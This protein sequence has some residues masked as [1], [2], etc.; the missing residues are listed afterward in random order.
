MSDYI[1]GYTG[2]QI[3][4]AVGKVATHETAIEALQ[5]SVEGKAD[6]SDVYS[7]SQVYTKTEI[8]TALAGK[9]ATLTFDNVPTESSN[10]PVKSGG[11]YSQLAEKVNTADVVDNLTTDNASKVLSAKQGKVLKDEVTSQEGTLYTYNNYAYSDNLTATTAQTNRVNYRT[12]N[13][14][15]KAGDKI[16][17]K[18]TATSGSWTRLLLWCNNVSGESS[19]GYRVKDNIANGVEYIV[20]LTEDITIL[21]FYMTKTSQVEFVMYI[22]RLTKLDSETAAE[23]AKIPDMENDISELSESSIGYRQIDSSTFISGK[24]VAPTTNQ[25]RDAGT[26]FSY[27]GSIRTDIIAVNEGDVIETNATFDAS[28]GAATYSANDAIPANFL[29]GISV[30]PSDHK[31]TIASGESY[32]VISCRTTTGYDSKPLWVKLITADGMFNTEISPMQNVLAAFDP[33]TITYQDKCNRESLY[34]QDEKNTFLWKQYDKAYFSWTND[35]A[36]SQDMHLYQ[37]VCAENN[38]P[39]CP[40][41]P[42]EKILTNPTIDGTTL[43]NRCKAIVEAGGEILMHGSTALADDSTEADWLSVFRDG[44]KIIEDAVGCDVNGIIKIGGTTQRPARVTDEYSQKFCLAYYKYS[45]MWGLTDQY[46]CNRTRYEI[47]SGRTEAQALELYKAAIDDAI[48]NH[49]WLR[50][51]CHGTSEVPISLLESIIDYINDTYSNSQY[52]WVTW[53]YMYENFKGYA[54][55]N[56]WVDE[57]ITESN[58]TKTMTATLQPNKVHYSDTAVDVANISFS[59]AYDRTKA[60]EVYIKCRSAN[61]S[62]NFNLGSGFNFA[63][64]AQ[65]STATNRTIH[66][67]IENY[68][69]YADYKD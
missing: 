55:D 2:E 49:K 9:Q 63:Y 61:T 13:Y 25:Y 34:V 60:Y 62:I 27:S 28:I 11:V 48:L 41:V 50:L 29:R 52:Q 46:K 31:I 44:K 43:I 8:D 1:S 30:T 21:G 14:P 12:L 42:W 24:C 54:L 6:S 22:E 56:L 64:N 3:D 40:A 35:D 66:I 65:C 37:A 4:T 15:I 23:I 67:K 51:Y 18:A 5:T 20:T 69:I 47:K 57:R 16:K 7:K 33:D 26:I 53:N 10:N 59:G 45:D 36:R 58:N 39:Y 17:I 38:I 32:I 19:E 68:I